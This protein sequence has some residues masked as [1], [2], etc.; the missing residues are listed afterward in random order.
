[1]PAGP[2]TEPEHPS[3]RPP[4][5]AR[6]PVPGPSSDGAPPPDQPAEDDPDA[7]QRGQTRR[8]LDERT[9][10]LVVAAVASVAILALLVLGARNGQANWPVYL[11]VIV[12]G[13]A[14]VVRV[15][16]RHHLSRTTRAGLAVFGVGHV[17]GG[18][19]PVGG[20]VLYGWWLVEPIIRFDNLQHAWGFGMVGR[21][22]WEVLRPRLPSSHRDPGLVA[23]VVV[24]SACTAGAVNE[25]LEWILTLTIPGTDVGGYDNTVRDLVSNLVGGLAIGTWTMRRAGPGRAGAGVTTPAP[26]G[27]PVAE[28]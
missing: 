17:A 24:L 18:M 11:A 8:I 1:M 23:I 19:I 21:A 2:D 25:I 14:V 7:G 28:R 16:R 22:S 20:G 10:N 9:W 4:E 5:R 27:A 3:H 15:D 26:V 13:V 12:V 6:V